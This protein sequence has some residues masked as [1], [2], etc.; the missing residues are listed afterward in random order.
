MSE[1]IGDDLKAAETASASC[2]V[3]VFLDARLCFNFSAAVCL[4]ACDQKVSRRYYQG[5]SGAVYSHLQPLRHQCHLD[6]EQRPVLH[7]FLLDK[8]VKLV[9]KVDHRIDTLGL[10]LRQMTTAF[11]V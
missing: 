9:H 1:A 11:S 4:S 2:V 5:L 3:V 8:V 6:M 10:V 7:L